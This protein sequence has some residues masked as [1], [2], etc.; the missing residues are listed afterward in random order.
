M[1]PVVHMAHLGESKLSLSLLI[2]SSISGDSHLETST[3]L[4]KP[5]EVISVP[6]SFTTQLILT[7]SPMVTSTL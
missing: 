7:F 4:L 1:A 2:F 6:P 5:H 3:E